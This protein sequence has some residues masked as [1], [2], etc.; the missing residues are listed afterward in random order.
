MK[1]GEF[2]RS[3]EWFKKAQRYEPNNK[4][5]NDA[6]KDLEKWEFTCITRNLEIFKVQLLNK[7]LLELAIDLKIKDCIVL[8]FALLSTSETGV[9]L[10][11]RYGDYL[12]GHDQSISPM[13][14]ASVNPFASKSGHSQNSTEFRFVKCW[15]TN[16]T[17]WKYCQRSFIWMVTIGFC[18]FLILES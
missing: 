4:A 14:L 11:R 1:E 9:V 13:P 8:A 10:K 5:I 7:E 12:G 18:L 17:L 6:L 3:R 2:D 15:K 16:G